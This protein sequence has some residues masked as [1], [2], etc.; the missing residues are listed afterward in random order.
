[1]SAAKLRAVRDQHSVHQH[2]CWRLTSPAM[3]KTPVMSLKI[4]AA[5]TPG[6]VG[7][8]FDELQMLLPFV[9]YSVLAR[10]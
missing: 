10:T 7:R 9:P 5:P 1:M 4:P 3:P 8:A 6:P 2:L